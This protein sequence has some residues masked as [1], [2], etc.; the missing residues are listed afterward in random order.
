MNRIPLFLSLAFLPLQILAD[1]PSPYT[2]PVER[3]ARKPLIFAKGMRSLNFGIGLS[4]YGGALELGAT[5]QIAYRGALR[6]KFH[7]E[8]GEEF[9]LGF[10][11][12]GMETGFEY[13]I[14]AFYDRFCLFAAAGLVQSFSRL[15]GEPGVQVDKRYN[16]GLNF[17][18]GLTYYPTQR[19]SIFV[20]P[21]QQ[22]FFTDT[23]GRYRS[24]LKTGLHFRLY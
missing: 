23:W 13:Y 16:T 5:A 10:V 12:M 21:E 15:Q 6:L 24:Y 19:F 7:F 4:P 1:G 17:G 14:L 20:Q 3:T 22:L 18:I 8:K 2:Y 11:R 9:N